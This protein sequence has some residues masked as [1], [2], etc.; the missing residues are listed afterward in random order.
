MTRDDINRL[1]AAMAASGT[2]ELLVEGTDGRICLRRPADT[3]AAPVPPSQDAVAEFAYAPYFGLLQTM[4][5][6]EAKVAPE[7]T[8][9]A[10]LR[11]D[12]VA[13]AV[14]AP[15]AGI[16]R[17]QAAAGTLIGYGQAV[18]RRVDPTEI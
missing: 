10:L 16:W 7:G 4:P 9:L 3:A 11:L 18:A 17:L 5:R 14:R 15:S 6:D 2:T 12:D 1:A 13:T 8:V